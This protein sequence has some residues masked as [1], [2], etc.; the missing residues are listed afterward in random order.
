MQPLTKNPVAWITLGVLLGLGAY[1]QRERAVFDALRRPGV[2]RRLAISFDTVAADRAQLLFVFQAQD[3]P[4]ALVTIDAVGD[5]ARRAPGAVRGILVGDTLEM[6]EWRALLRANKV[7]FP[8]TVMSY[9]DAAILLRAVQAR[10]TP[11][12]LWVD[13]RT[14]QVQRGSLTGPPPM[15]R[16]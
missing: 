8:V 15:A 13:P 16:R 6:P 1:R 3:C 10:Q 12:L 2:L 9:G 4:K 7:R 11:M 5:K 14:G